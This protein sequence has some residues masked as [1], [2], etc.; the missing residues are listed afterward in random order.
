ML[1]LNEMF[2]GIL[3]HDLRNPL[4]AILMHAHLLQRQSGEE[5]TR[6][7]AGQILASGKRMRRLITDLLD[8]ARSRFGGGIPI[9][10]EELDLGDIARRVVREC[11]ASFG[12]R[13]VEVTSRGDLRGEW[14]AERVSQVLSNLLSNAL[15]HGR[16]D[17]PVVVDLDGGDAAQVVIEVRNG[18]RLPPELIP[19]LFDPFHG[20]SRATDASPG[21]GLGLFIVREILRAHG[22]SVDAASSDDTTRFTVVL[23]RKP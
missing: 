8:L 15:R 17:A 16:Q 5:S 1:Q 22:G 9:Q 12:G 10:P 2:V 6:E 23:P 11:R 20:A 4:G 7:T 19:S 13:D 14:D 3:G 18:G 21:L